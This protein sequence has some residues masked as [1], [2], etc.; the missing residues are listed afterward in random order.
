M[1]RSLP[2]RQ[3]SPARGPRG[4]RAAYYTSHTTYQQQAVRAFL[5]WAIEAEHLPPADLPVMQF[6]RGSGF[7][8]NERLA[9]IRRFATSD[10]L[11]LYLRA[12]AC[13]LLL[14][15]TPLSRVVRLTRDDLI[16]EDSEAYLRLGTPPAP[17]PEPFAPV[18]EPFAPVPEPFA[19]VP[20]PFAPVPEPFAPV[21]EPFAS[22][23]DE[24]AA[25]G[26]GTGWLFPGPG[27]LT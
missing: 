22:M 5:T 3:P 17:V 13:L 26:A 7:T 4:S 2:R 10:D 16:R 11:P 20:E 25:E 6:T 27:L 18:P 15:A 23:L 8:Q 14:S 1:K 12:A 24:L 21:P 19:P 9:L